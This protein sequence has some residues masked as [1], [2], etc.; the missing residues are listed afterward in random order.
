MGE[1]TSYLRAPVRDLARRRQLR[2]DVGNSLG[3]HHPSRIRSLRFDRVLV[4]F[5][6]TTIVE[7]IEGPESHGCGHVL[8]KVRQRRRRKTRPEEELVWSSR[9]LFGTRSRG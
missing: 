5:G 6:L 3:I 7:A 4:L 2:L 8:M 1:V 9:C